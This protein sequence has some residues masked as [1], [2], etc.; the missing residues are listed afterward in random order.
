[1]KGWVLVSV[2]GLVV[3]VAA[4]RFDML[5]SGLRPNDTIRV[6]GMVL[7]AGAV[8]AGLAVLCG[9]I[10]ARLPGA[11]AAGLLGLALA[12]AGYY[13]YGALLGDRTQV[14]F[15]GLTGVIRLWAMF[16]LVAGPILGV[17]GALIRRPGWIGFVAALVVPAGVLVEMIGI[18]RLG[19]ETFAV[20]PALG[21]GQAGLVVLAIAGAAAAAIRLAR[22]GAGSRG[23]VVTDR[24]GGDPWPA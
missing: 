20:D 8:W 17:V 11:A 24:T 9:W 14:G 3:G 10:I 16:A 5:G 7:N 13:A 22:P 23:D 2:A 4:A 19:L 6:V 15:G 21:W 12:V 1:M 18:R